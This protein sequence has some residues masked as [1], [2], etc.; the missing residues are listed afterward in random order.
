MFI[1]I[2]VYLL[3]MLARGKLSVRYLIILIEC[4]PTR[5]VDRGKQKGQSNTVIVEEIDQK[6]YLGPRRDFA[7]C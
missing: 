4:V 1:I 2:A 7:G 6:Q 5:L 3:I